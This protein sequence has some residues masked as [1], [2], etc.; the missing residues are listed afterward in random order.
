MRDDLACAECGA[1]I[2]RQSRSGLCRLHAMRRKHA[3]PAFR[4][5]RAAGLARHYAKPGAREACARRLAD[6]REN[7]PEADRER[8][9][10]HGRGL[11]RDYLSRPDIHARSQSPEA[12]RRAVEGNE[13][14]KLGWCPPELRGAYTALIRSKKVPAA[15]ARRI[16]EGE[17]A[18]TVEHARRAIANA[19]LA[20]QLRHEREQA[21]A[22]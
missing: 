13:A 22:Y 6:W 9:R 20:A 2:T 1:R 18:G 21:E 3:D 7:M 10:E 11:V 12:R 19:Q 15:E 4:A 8:L 5:A 16:I 14:A 17:I